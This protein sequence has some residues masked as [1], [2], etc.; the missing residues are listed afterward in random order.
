[1]LTHCDGS[2]AQQE[3]AGQSR[4]TDQRLAQGFIHFNT[5]LERYLVFPIFS[6]GGLLIESPHIEE[7]D[8]EFWTWVSKAKYVKGAPIIIHWD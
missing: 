7:P 2:N 8:M 3:E 5:T 6:M 4:F 1:M